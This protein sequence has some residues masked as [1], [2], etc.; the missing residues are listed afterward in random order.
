MC[1]ATWAFRGGPGAWTLE[2]GFNRDEHRSRPKAHPP[3]LRRPAAGGRA[4]IAPRDPLGGGSWLAVNDAGICLA[5]LN[6]YPADGPA[7]R[8][9][10]TPSPGGSPGT[11]GVPLP[12]AADPAPTAS[13]MAAPFASTPATLSPPAP[14]G[15]AGA[16]G[17]RFSR[18]LLPWRLASLGSLGAMAEELAALTARESPLPFQLLLLQ[19]GRTRLAQT[20]LWD[21]RRLAAV[22]L[23]GE[24][25]FL[26]SSAHRGAEVVAGRRRRYAAAEA[27]MDGPEARWAFHRGHEP[28]RGAWSVCMHRPEARSVSYCQVR[29]TPKDATVR[30]AAGAP[31]RAA[32]GPE[33]GLELAP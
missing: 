26:S 10:G 27:A 6:R 16:A 19:G 5:L 33:L 32:L 7:F 12:T 3:R 24:L 18:G 14:A 20:W 8:P 23:S 11:D 25:P 30:Y 2:L 4:F 17:P 29:V 15:A 28:E 1:T 21:G 22:D 9:P 13:P 31:C